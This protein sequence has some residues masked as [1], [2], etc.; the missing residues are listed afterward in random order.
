MSNE[1]IKTKVEEILK[2][3]KLFE[4]FE[5]PSDFKS[6]DFIKIAKKIGYLVNGNEKSE[7]YIYG[8][9]PEVEITHKSGDEIYKHLSYGVV[10]LSRTS[11]TGKKLFGSSIVHQNFISLSINHAEMIQDINL[12]NTHYFPKKRIIEVFLTS[13]QFAELITTM[14]YGEGTPCTISFKEPIGII[15]YTEPDSLKPNDE[16]NKMQDSAEKEKD[17]TI[18]KISTKLKTILSKNSIGKK[19]KQNIYSMF[20]ILSKFVDDKFEFMQSQFQSKM[21]KHITEAKTEIDSTLINM[22]L[23]NQKRIELENSND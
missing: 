2:D 22:S 3:K 4:K 6:K 11:T 8:V 23:N 16:L 10:S 17:D 1:E 9:N 21:E 13:S 12:H 15:N 7:S 20:D 14:N 5:I 18:E 19:D